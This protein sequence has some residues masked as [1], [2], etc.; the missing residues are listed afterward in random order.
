MDE[1]DTDAVVAW[2]HSIGYK[3]FDKSIKEHQVGGQKMQGVRRS[4]GG[5]GA[6]G[7]GYR[8]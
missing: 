5:N 2:F 1:W 3:Q 7:G 8:K 6:G 4:E